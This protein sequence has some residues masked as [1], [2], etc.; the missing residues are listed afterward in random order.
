MFSD[1]ITVHVIRDLVE[2]IVALDHYVRIQTSVKMVVHASEYSFYILFHTRDTFIFIMFVHGSLL[3]L[4]IFV[5]PFSRSIPLRRNHILL[6]IFSTYSRSDT[7]T[8]HLF[9]LR[10]ERWGR[11]G[12]RRRI[13]I[14]S[15]I[16][17]GMKIIRLVFSRNH[18]YLLDYLNEKWGKTE[19]KFYFGNLLGKY[20]LI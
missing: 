6:S 9:I 20:F 13:R 17:C 14:V 10:P 11:K 18:L 16:S 19:S 15:S 2:L 4:S 1:L 3:I 12:E 7:Y 5:F 8:R